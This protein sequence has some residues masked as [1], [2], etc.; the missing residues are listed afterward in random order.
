MSEREVNALSESAL[1]YDGKRAGEL[2]APSH[3]KRKHNPSFIEPVD[4]LP[5]KEKDEADDSYAEVDNRPARRNTRN[6]CPSSA[7]ESEPTEPSI[8]S[9]VSAQSS[10]A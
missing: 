5:P 7:K 10:A 1:Y 2:I 6:S 9:K 8:R 4:D 3:E